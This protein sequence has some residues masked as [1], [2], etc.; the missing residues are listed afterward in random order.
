MASLLA[1]L[2]SDIAADRTQLRSK[3]AAYRDPE[4]R[5]TLVKLARLA[6]KSRVSLSSYYEELH[7]TYSVEGLD[8]FKV[9]ALPRFLE[10]LIDA[11]V[12]FRSST[13]YAQSGNRDFEGRL[14]DVRIRVAAY[15]SEQSKQCSIRE[16]GVETTTRP[17]YEIFC[18]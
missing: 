6:G 1:K 18:D 7:V 4:L 11:G 13:D 16:V 2:R 8:S 12:E 3:L 15:L 14:G 17:K 5:A 10:R 9:G